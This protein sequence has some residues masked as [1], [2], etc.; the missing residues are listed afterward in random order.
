VE[1]I[2]AAKILLVVRYID[3]FDDAASNLRNRVALKTTRAETLLRDQAR[4]LARAR[5]TP[6]AVI[7]RAPRT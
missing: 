3:A 7:R 5:T 2:T 1:K 6:L 4:K